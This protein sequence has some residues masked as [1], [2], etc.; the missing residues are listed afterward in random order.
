MPFRVTIT[1]DWTLSDESIA[2]AAISIVII[3]FIAF[4]L[5]VGQGIGDLQIIVL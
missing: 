3:L 1:W 2:K 4:L 5:I